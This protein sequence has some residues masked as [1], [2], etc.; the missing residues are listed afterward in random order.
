MDIGFSGSCALSMMI[1]LLRSPPLGPLFPAFV[2]LLLV[3][4][5]T[6]RALAHSG[7]GRTIWGIPAEALGVLT[8][9]NM[10]LVGATKANSYTR[11]E[12]K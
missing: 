9:T 3:P 11:W 4:F 8:N 1:A 2:H 7:S 12:W 10:Q 6:K 5:R